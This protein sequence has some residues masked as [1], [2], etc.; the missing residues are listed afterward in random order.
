MYDKLCSRT[1]LDYI[2]YVLYAGR[3]SPRTFWSASSLSSAISRGAELLLA[4]AVNMAS[5][6]AS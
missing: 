2:L 1:R 3:F 6:L 4:A 5:V